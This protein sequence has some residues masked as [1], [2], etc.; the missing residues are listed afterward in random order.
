[1]HHAKKVQS[2]KLYKATRKLLDMKHA[3]TIR[4]C[5]L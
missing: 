2:F 5:V 4:K 3:Q 1:M